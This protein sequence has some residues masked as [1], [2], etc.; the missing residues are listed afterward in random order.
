MPPRHAAQHVEGVITRVEQHLM[1]LLRIGP[2]NEG[3]AVGEL[4][5]GDLQFGSLAAD[6]G[7]V[8]LPV[9]PKRLA[10]RRQRHES[11]ATAGL[12]FPLAGGLPVAGEGRHAIVR[13]VMA[14]GGQVSVQLLDRPLLLVRLP[15]PLPPI[16][17]NLSA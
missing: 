9:E 16:C 5:A 10:G 13:A 17:D 2:E 12:E 11:A 15:G 3:A 1:G 4:E 7:P 8:F 6:Q 14:E